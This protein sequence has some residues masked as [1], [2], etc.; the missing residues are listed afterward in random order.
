MSDE[1]ILP[2][3]VEIKG[4]TG[5]DTTVTVGGHLIPCF[6]ADL[7]LDAESMPVLTLTLPVVDGV[8]ITLDE[9]EVKVAQDSRDA[10]LAAGWTPPQEPP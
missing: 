4:K 6:S 5:W 2:A 7:H 8:V 9:A 1:C 10:L 3:K